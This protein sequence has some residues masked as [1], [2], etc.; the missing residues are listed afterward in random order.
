MPVELT[1]LIEAAQKATPGPW[2][3][4]NGNF[5]VF[6]AGG[7]SVARHAISV[8]ADPQP[9]NNAR[10]IAAAHPQ[11]ILLMAAE[12]KDLRRKLKKAESNERKN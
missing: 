10:Y 9:E 2:F 4:D 5:D 6:D 12:I 7:S 3:C 1:H 11:F 8:G